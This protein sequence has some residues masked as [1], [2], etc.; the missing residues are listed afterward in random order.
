MIGLSEP[1]MVA[2]ASMRVLGEMFVPNVVVAS[3]PVAAKYVV[4]VVSVSAILFFG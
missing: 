3:L 4:A 2:K 1:I